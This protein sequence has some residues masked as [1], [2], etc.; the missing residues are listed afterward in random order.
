MLQDEQLEHQ[1]DVG[2]L[3]SGPTGSISLIDLLEQGR[4]FLPGNDL[5]EPLQQGFLFVEL[6]LSLFS[7]PEP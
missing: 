2:G 3:A 4:K 7:I 5:I 6:L 1:D